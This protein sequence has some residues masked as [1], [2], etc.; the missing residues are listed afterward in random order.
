MQRAGLGSPVFLAGGGWRTGMV[1]NATE[2]PP[3]IFKASDL[4]DLI[5]KLGGIY[6][7]GRKGMMG[8]GVRRG[9]EEIAER[10]D[11]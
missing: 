5:G 9:L 1:S 3:F 11:Y 2:D 8:Q 4:G 10:G 6:L 7:R